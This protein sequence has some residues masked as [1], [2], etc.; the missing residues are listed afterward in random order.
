MAWQIWTYMLKDHDFLSDGYTFNSNM[1]ETD[2]GV[3]VIGKKDSS[4]L[5]IQFNGLLNSVLSK[6][7]VESSWLNSDTK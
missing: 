1:A 5:K 7:S 2:H 4:F 6:T 3:F